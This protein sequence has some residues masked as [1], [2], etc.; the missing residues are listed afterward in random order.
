MSGIGNR[1]STWL[2]KVPVAGG[3][4]SALRRQVLMLRR[5]IAQRRLESVLRRRLLA[6]IELP[7]DDADKSWLCR[8]KESVLRELLVQLRDINGASAYCLQCYRG[9]ADTLRRFG[10]RIEGMRV[11]ELGPGKNIGVGVL[12]AVNGA[13]SYCGVDVFRDQEFNAPS[14]LRSLVALLEIMP[15]LARPIADVVH[16]HGDGGATVD[17]RYVEFRCPVDVEQLPFAAGSFDYVFSNAAFEHFSGPDAAIGEIHRVLRRGGMTAHQVDLRDHRFM[18]NDPL[19]FLK[20]GEAEWASLF[21]AN[22]RVDIAT[23]NWTNRWRAGRYRDAFVRRG[24]RLLEYSPQTLPGDGVTASLRASC[25]A[26]FRDLP[27]EDL[28]SVGLFLVAEK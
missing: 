8:T 2:R 12:F 3:A 22:V 1:L 27:V 20:L 21:P 11:L 6:G 26:D 4:A 13:A 9:Q 5:R 7:V 19:A 16:L 25:H 24:F 23:A 10:R 18:D 15:G 14:V 28:A 17:E